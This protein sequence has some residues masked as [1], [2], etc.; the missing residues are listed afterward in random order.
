MI[1]INK[2]GSP[3]VEGNMGEQTEQYSINFKSLSIINKGWAFSNS[4]VFDICCLS[5]SPIR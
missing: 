5:G 1:M 2:V 4:Y 3:T